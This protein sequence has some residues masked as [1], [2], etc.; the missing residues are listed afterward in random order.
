MRVRHQSNSAATQLR[1][2]IPRYLCVPV[3]FGVCFAIC[4]PVG[5]DAIVPGLVLAAAASGLVIFL[6]RRNAAIVLVGIAGGESLVF[7]A[8]K[9]SHSSDWRAMLIT[10]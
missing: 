2:S 6:N 3:A 9:H 7:S 10:C 4:R 8:G 1:F 5:G